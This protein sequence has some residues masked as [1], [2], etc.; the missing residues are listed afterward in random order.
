MTTR[1]LA[2]QQAARYPLGAHVDVYVN[3]KNPKRA[4]LEPRA[5]NDIA[6]TIVF[7]VIFGVIALVLTAHS[8]AG[9]VLYV[10]NGVPMFV[11]ASLKRVEDLPGLTLSLSIARFPIFGCFCLCALIIAAR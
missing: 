7:A 4:V 8:I 5:Q 6:G 2:M 9:H 1:L 10:D 11:S 3:P